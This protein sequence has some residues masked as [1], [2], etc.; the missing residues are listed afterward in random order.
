M[1][2]RWIIATVAGIVMSCNT[3]QQKPTSGLK[4]PSENKITETPFVEH[5]QDGS[6]KMQGKLRG[7]KRVGKWEAFYPNGYKW[8]EVNYRDGYKHGSTTAFYENGI[9][10][11]QGRYENDDYSDLWIFYDTTGTIIKQINM[12]ELDAIPDSLLR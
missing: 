10:R 3:P 5:Y 2:K 1:M 7:E 11:Y 12:D 9:M 4:Q 8:S 6:I